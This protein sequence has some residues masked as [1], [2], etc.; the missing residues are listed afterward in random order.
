MPAVI[1]TALPAEEQA[2]SAVLRE[3]FTP[4]ARA[5]GREITPEAFARLA[6]AIARGDVRV[7]VEGDAILGLM[8]LKHDD[9]WLEVD[10]LAV[11]HAHQKRGIGRALLA[12][13]E[14]IARAAGVATLR[15]H[16]AAM[17]GHLLQLYA[18]AGYVETHRAPPPHGADAYPRVFFEKNL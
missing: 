13:A 18:S 17:F 1:R 5:L 15:L 4:Y 9:G 7:A 12:D 14:T 16:T 6:G 3:A 10:Q 8:T 2:A 11:A